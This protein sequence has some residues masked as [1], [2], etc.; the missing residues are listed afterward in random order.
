MP[1]NI[2][3]ISTRF[4]GT[5]GVS[6]E[7]AKWA[8]VLWDDRHISYWYSG[9]SDRSKDIAYVVPEAHFGHPENEWINERL[10]KRTQRDPLVSSRIRDLADYLKGTLH[11]F[12]RRYNLDFIIPQNVL[13]IPMHVPLGIAVT[14]FLAETGMP[15]IAHHHDFYWERTRFSVGCIQDYLDAAFPPSLSNIRNVV[16]NRPAQEQFALRKGESALLIPN[17]FDFDQPAPQPDE[18]SADIREQIGLEKDDLLILQPTRIVPRKGIEHA[19]TAVGMLKDPRCKLVISHAAGDEGMDYKHMLEE[20]AR[21]EGVD[22]RFFDERI[23]EVRQFD[24]EGRKI[25]TLWDLYPHA[26]FVTYPSTYEGFGNALL[27]AVYFR[28]PTLVNRYSIFIQD[29]EPK[30]FR[31]ALMDGIV[32]NRVVREIKRILDDPAYREEMCE[33]NYRVARR[34]YSYTVLRRSLRTLMTALTGLN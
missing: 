29:I 21:E 27:E 13:T 31:F 14:E 8:E 15:A 2:G 9:L 5:D 18:Y 4:A 6:L 34:H 11:D 32:T 7:S 20:K 10:W 23:G 33:H 28:K 12:A 24:D 30:G 25:Y 1:K 19:I 22:V 3:F 26:D 16:I 17:V